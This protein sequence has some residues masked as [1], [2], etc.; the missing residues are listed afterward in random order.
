LKIILFK[1]K[2]IEALTAEAVE[3]V[4]EAVLQDRSLK[5]IKPVTRRETVSRQ[6]T[7][8]Q[9]SVCIYM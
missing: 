7:T 4:R 8:V 1:G 3:L 2:L 9:T 6:W 5:F